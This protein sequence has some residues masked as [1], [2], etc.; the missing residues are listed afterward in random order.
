MK[1][2]NVRMVMAVLLTLSAAGFARADLITYIV[3]STHPTSFASAKSSKAKS[4]FGS[5]DNEI[6][7]QSG[8]FSSLSGSHFASQTFEK[9][10]LISTEIAPICADTPEITLIPTGGNIPGI[11]PP[12]VGTPDLNQ[13]VSTPG[14]ALV[15]PDSGSSTILVALALCALIGFGKWSRSA[16]PSSRAV[17]KFGE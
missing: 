3:W 13:V 15:V 2:L 6:F 5:F 4:G 1:K 8:A 16:A 12:G 17:H 10:N 14:A 9:F 11:F 7:S